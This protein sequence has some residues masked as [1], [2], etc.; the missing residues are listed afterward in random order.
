MKVSLAASALLVFL[1]ACGG[2]SDPAGRSAPP[3][4]PDAPVS[5]V[6]SQRADVPS[7]SPSYTVPEPGQADVRPIAWDSYNVGS[8][9]NIYIS[10][11]S[12]VE[13]CYVLDRV[14]VDYGLK[15]VT[16]TL[17]EGHTETAEDVACIEIAVLK[18][19]VIEP[20]EPVGDR[21][22]VDGAHK[23]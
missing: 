16:V 7:A 12:G 22:V 9:G 10:Y 4:D 5:S 23:A 20:E 14:E 19:T 8:D 2:G 18:T 11:W 6:P 13:P 15:T 1:A 21:P 3:S 17:F